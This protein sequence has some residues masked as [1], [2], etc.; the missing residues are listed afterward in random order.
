[1]KFSSPKNHA[2]PRG[3]PV[4]ASVNDTLRGAG[5]VAGVLV[6]L[7]NAAV[8]AA[9]EARPGSTIQQRTIKNN[10]FKHDIVSP[11]FM[12]MYSRCDICISTL[13]GI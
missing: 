12:V 7:E 10:F 11:F 2:Q 8:G 9:A 6:L 5:P 1:V 3:E 13:S 4:D